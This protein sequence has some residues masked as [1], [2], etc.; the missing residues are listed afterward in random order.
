MAVNVSLIRS[1]QCNHSDV[2]NDSQLDFYG[3]RLAT[4]SSDST[5]NIYDISTDES[6][7]ITTLDGH[8]GPVWQISWSDPSYG[9]YLASCSYDKK[10][11]IW[12]E[13]VS[14]WEKD[15]VHITHLSSLTGI[16][17]APIEHGLMLACASYDCTISIIS[18]N[19]KKQWEYLIITD[20]GV[21][22]ICWAPF[23]YGYNQEIYKQIAVGGIEGFIKI[24]CYKDEKWNQ[25]EILSGEQD[26]TRSVS[27]TST[28]L[29][30][31]SFIASAYQNGSV[32]IWSKNSEDT[33]WESQM[34]KQF[35]DPV[36]HVSWSDAGNVLSVS[37]GDNDVSIGFI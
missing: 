7:L 28:N 15:Y 18:L 5:I 3:R 11:I 16:S 12:K 17:W 8:D 27:W 36:W 6:K 26:S 25:T 14:H 24:Y 9:C 32:L 21:T 20:I 37:S 30:S 34:I 4:C 35:Q 13:N 29:E 22:C 19:D 33:H 10:V 23:C 2:V 1:V 31:K